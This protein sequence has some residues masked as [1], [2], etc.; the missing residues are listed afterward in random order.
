MATEATLFPDKPKDERSVRDI[1]L[2]IERKLDALLL[3]SVA[4]PSQAEKLRRHYSIVP[5]QKQR[6]AIVL[7][8][9]DW[10]ATGKR[11]TFHALVDAVN[12]IEPGA[13]CRGGETNHVLRNLCAERAGV[14][15]RWRARED[16]ED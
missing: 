8:L 16:E 4:A 1:M 15:V 7:V 12:E 3:Q 5:T 9:D 14:I 13:L 6:D 10:K 11:G 2:S